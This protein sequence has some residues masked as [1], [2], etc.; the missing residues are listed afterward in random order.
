MIT[1]VPLIRES[2]VEAYLRC[3]RQ[4][5]LGTERKETGS[6]PMT[7]FSAKHYW[8]ESAMRQLFPEERHVGPDLA[9]MESLRGE[10]LAKYLKFHSPEAFA[11]ATAGNWA[12]HVIS[13]KG[14]VHDRDV[15]WLYHNQW[16]DSKNQIQKICYNFYKSLMDEGPPVLYFTRSG[17]TPELEVVF[18]HDGRK[19]VTKLGFVRR[20]M[21]IGEYG[22]SQRT[23]KEVG[24]DWKITLRLLAFCTLAHQE[25]AHRIKWGVP[26]EAAERWGG[27]EMFIDPSVTYRHHCLSNNK[28]IET[29]R[30]DFELDEML[31]KIREAEK[32]MKEEDFSAIPDKDQCSTCRFSVENK[33]NILICPEKHPDVHFAPMDEMHFG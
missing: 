4:Y 26:P 12:R 27:A 2:A 20:G 21:V 19:Y 22:T 7:G 6:I 30:S 8:L 18:I 29:S 32:G 15:L 1:K 9:D 25:E 24:S 3:P 33:A 31:Q 13:G 23:K 5:F 11:N 28:V 16:W 10:E 14:K 17:A